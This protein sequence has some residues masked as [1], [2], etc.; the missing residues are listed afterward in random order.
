M[1]CGH[2]LMPLPQ[3]H[4]VGNDL[5]IVRYQIVTVFKVV[6]LEAWVV[7]VELIVV[8]VDLSI[9]ASFRVDVVLFQAQGIVERII[10]F[11]VVHMLL[12]ALG[13]H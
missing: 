12:T 5:G 13:F 11:G 2:E 8:S 3:R 1:W 4:V 10:D 6:I 7:E 9:F